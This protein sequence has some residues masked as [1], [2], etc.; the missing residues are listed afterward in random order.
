[1]TTGQKKVTDNFKKAIAYRKKTGVSLKEAFAYVYGKKVGVT[2]KKTKLGDVFVTYPSENEAEYVMERGYHGEFKGHKRIAG[3][4]KKYTKKQLEKI[5][6]DYAYVTEA[7]FDKVTYRLLDKDYTKKLL[8]VY[9]KAIQD[10]KKKY[11]VKVLGVIKK[12][13]V[14]KVVAKKAALKKKTMPKKSTN[15]HKDTKSHNVNIR[16]VSGFVGRLIIK[17]FTL[18]ELKKMNP[19]YFEK[20]KDKSVGIYKRKLIISKKL[21]SQVMIEAK[22]DPILKIKSYSV[23]LINPEGSISTPKKFD[24]IFDAANYIGKNIII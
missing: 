17:T 16:V 8:P 24:S 14:K 15:F 19:I 5:A 20:G 21:E 22:K 13:P 11:N 1:M 3:A 12:A 7:D 4:N 10:W 18:S 23:R 2:A 6:S 9:L